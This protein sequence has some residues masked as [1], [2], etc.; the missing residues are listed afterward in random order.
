MHIE[1]APIFEISKNKKSPSKLLLK[2]Y[3]VGS[4]G[5]KKLRI[6]TSSKILP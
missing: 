2:G 3:F 1:N 6:F 4:L 5:I